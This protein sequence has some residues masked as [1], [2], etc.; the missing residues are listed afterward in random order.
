MSVAGQMTMEDAEVFIKEYNAK[1]KP[2]NGADYDLYVDCTDMKLLNQ[3]MSKDLTEVMKMY[4]ETGFKTITFTIKQNVTLKMQLSR[5]AKSAG[6][7]DRVK[8]VD[9]A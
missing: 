2:L 6:I 3:D 5:I 8:V 1:I 9:E 4:K 7:M